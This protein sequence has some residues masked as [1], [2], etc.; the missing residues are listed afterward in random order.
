[1][2]RHAVARCIRIAQVDLPDASSCA[3]RSKGFAPGLSHHKVS[4]GKLRAHVAVEQRP[5]GLELESTRTKLSGAG[6]PL[7]CAKSDLA[8]RYEI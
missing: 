5:N 4:L 2:L 7:A 3:L 6:R 1:M 8:A